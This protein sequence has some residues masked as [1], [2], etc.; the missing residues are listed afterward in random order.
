MWMTGV[1]KST[2]NGVDV[3]E[4]WELKKDRMVGS[5]VWSWGGKQRTEQ[6]SIFYRGDSLIYKIILEDKKPLYFT[7]E[8]CEND[9]LVFINN[10]NDFPK[11]LV[12]VKPSGKKMNV[13]IDNEEKDPNRITFPFEKAAAK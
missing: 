11:R 8:D 2:F 10:R 13:W 4:T 12:Y 9:T 1:W 3:C 7:C 6:L 5:T